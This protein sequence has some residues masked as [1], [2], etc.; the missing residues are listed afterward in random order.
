MTQ[1]V[2]IFRL[3]DVHYFLFKISRRE[4]KPGQANKF[5]LKESVQQHAVETERIAEQNILFIC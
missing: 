1:R 2:T 4:L 5:T 3:P